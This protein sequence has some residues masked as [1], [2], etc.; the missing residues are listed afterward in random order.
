M[1]LLEVRA[2]PGI[3]IYRDMTTLIDLID[4]AAG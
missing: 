4:L 3:V 1:W 2:L